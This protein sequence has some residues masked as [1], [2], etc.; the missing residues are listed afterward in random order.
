MK[1]LERYFIAGLLIVLPLS[2]SIYLLLAIFKFLDGI[3]GRYINGYLKS[4]FGFFIPGIGIIGG[5]ILILVVGFFSYLLSKN[6]L[7]AIEGWFLRFPGARLIY[8][9]IKQI[10]TFIFSKKEGAFKKVVLV[11]YPSK[12]IWS[13]GFMTNES[14]R[15]AEEAAGAKLVHVLIGSTPSPWSGY[16]I[17][18]PKDE[19]KYLDIS[20]EEGM[21]LIL[22]GGITKPS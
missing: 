2:I 5:V 9:P 16:F 6:A 10:I 19:V 12:G 20:V 1:I 17:L 7:P 22:S 8:L 4:E 21:K 13:I 11:Q 15:E 14:F 3:L 18:V